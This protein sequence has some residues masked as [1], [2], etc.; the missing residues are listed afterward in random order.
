[1]NSFKV[2]SLIMCLILDSSIYTGRIA[3]MPSG[4]EGEISTQSDS[5]GY[6]YSYINN[7]LYKRLYNFSTNTPLS[8][9]ILCN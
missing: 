9:W 3:L 5:I 8:D 2:F 1:M 7:K 4:E 6:Q